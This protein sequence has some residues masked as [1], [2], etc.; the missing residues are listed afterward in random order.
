[1]NNTQ[2]LDRNSRIIRKLCWFFIVVGVVE[3]F[4]SVFILKYVGLGFLAVLILGVIPGLITTLSANIT[5]NKKEGRKKGYFG[6]IWNMLKYNPIS[7]S[8]FVFILSDFLAA[9]SIS[10]GSYVVILIALLG[11]ISFVCSIILAIKISNHNRILT[12]L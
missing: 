1:M 3:I 2:K 12:N 9:S 8:M 7:L 10:I 6:S 4:I 5:L 11:I